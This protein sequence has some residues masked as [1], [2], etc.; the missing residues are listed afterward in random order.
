M[1]CLG[2]IRTKI[3]QISKLKS[4]F[5]DNLCVPTELWNFVSFL[6]KIKIIYYIFSF[7]AGQ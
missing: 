6:F 5:N 2:C 1:C 4:D 7:L 3:L